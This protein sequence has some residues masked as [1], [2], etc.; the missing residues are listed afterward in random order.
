MGFSIASMSRSATAD[1]TVSRMSRT[2]L[3]AAI[4]S[5]LIAQLAIGQDE[6][7]RARR[8]QDLLNANCSRCHAIG[9]T[10]ASP[11][12]AAPAFRTL[13]RKYPIEGLGEALAEG[14][15]VGHPDMPDFVFEP[16][17]VGAIL[18]YLTSIQER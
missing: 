18:D 7:G 3:A 8:A 2:L 1:I 10:G 5:S 17:D 14:L 13:S 11:H 15:S 6:R 9:R 12:A 16:E 4:A